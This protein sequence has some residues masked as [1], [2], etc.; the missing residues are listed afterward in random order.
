MTSFDYYSTAKLAVVL[1][2]IKCGA[3]LTDLLKLL[4]SKLR[5]T[6]QSEILLASNH[7]QMSNQDLAVVMIKRIIIIKAIKIKI[8]IMVIIMTVITTIIIRL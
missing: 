5:H 4:G 1:R 2:F 3:G 6:S 8:I 7:R